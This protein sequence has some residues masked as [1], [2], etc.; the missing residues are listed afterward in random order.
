MVSHT[1]QHTNVQPKH[2]FPAFQSLTL[3][4]FFF[5]FCRCFF[6]P[7]HC[8]ISRRVSRPQFSRATPVMS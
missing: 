4:F 2:R 7:V 5:F 6:C 8:G 1:D 3:C